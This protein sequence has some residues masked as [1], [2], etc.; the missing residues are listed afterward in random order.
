[1]KC[2]LIMEQLTA[3]ADGEL[4]LEDAG[5]VRSHLSQCPLCEQEWRELEKI[6]HWVKKSRIAHD[7]YLQKKVLKSV[8][9]MVRPAEKFD[10]K[11][12]H[13]LPAWLQWSTVG[14]FFLAG[15]LAAYF[16]GYHA[17]SVEVA[18]SGGISRTDLEKI[19]REI[20]FFRNYEIVHNLDVIENMDKNFEDGI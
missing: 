3:F 20:D 8:R 13:L 15:F 11:R 4:S 16:A 1:M 12:P 5:I 19:N 6:D 7:P 2:D 17:G 14:T 10:I 18:Q 9:G